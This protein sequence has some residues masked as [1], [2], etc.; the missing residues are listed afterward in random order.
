M[1]LAILF[2]IESNSINRLVYNTMCCYKVYWFHHIYTS[3]I[4][5]EVICEV[6]YIK[7]IE[8][9]MSIYMEICRKIKKRKGKL[10]FCFGNN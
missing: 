10:N 9:Y 6:Q 3:C 4:L 7:Y 1:A 8:L 5:Y 2:C